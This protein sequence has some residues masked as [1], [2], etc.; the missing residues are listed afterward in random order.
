MVPA[1]LELD[2]DLRPRVV[3]PVALLDQAVV[4]QDEQQPD[5]QDD[6][7]DDEQPDHGDHD[8]MDRPCEWQT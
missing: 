2:L 3:D 8:S 6:A 7:E 1:P 4:E 5:E